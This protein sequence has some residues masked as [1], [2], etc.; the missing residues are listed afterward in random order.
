[1]IDLAIRQDGLF[2]C[3]ILTFSCKGAVLLAKK[4]YLLYGCNIENA[5]YTPTNCA[6][7]NRFFSKRSVKARETFRQSVSLAARIGV[8]KTEHA[9]PCGVC[10]QVMMEFCDPETFQ[11]ILAVSREKYDI[12]FYVKGTVAIWIWTDNL[13]ETEVISA[14]GYVQRF[15]RYECSEK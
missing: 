8:P 3:A 10:R 14:C 2:L 12:F 13:E 4:R 1:M 6:E 9:A 5:A 7:R 15:S 11:I